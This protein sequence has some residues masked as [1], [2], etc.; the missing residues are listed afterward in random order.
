MEDLPLD[1]LRHYAREG[2]R[3]FALERALGE[4]RAV[5]R[6][7]RVVAPVVFA[8][9]VERVQTD[10]SISAQVSVGLDR[11]HSAVLDDAAIASIEAALDDA[12]Q[13]VAGHGERPRLG[14]RLP[15]AEEARYGVGGPS[16]ALATM[17]SAV[18]A[19]TGQKP[20][21]SVLVTGSF[22]HEIDSLEPKLQ[23]AKRVARE[24]D[25][26]PS[27]PL[28]VASANRP[29]GE[30]FKWV[31][32]AR[33]AVSHVF[34]SSP[35][36][37][38]ARYACVHIAA[39]PRM[40][41]PPA[42]FE[43]RDPAIVRLYDELGLGERLMRSSDLSAALELRIIEAFTNGRCYEVSGGGP[44]VLAAWLG[45]IL[46]SHGA[47]LRVID[48][49]DNAPCWDNRSII[50]PPEGTIRR[51]ATGPEGTTCPPGWELVKISPRVEPP[52]VAETVAAVM[53]SLSPGRIDVAVASS[54]G[55]AWGLGHA[56]K[57]RTA[58]TFH[59]YVK[60]AQDYE[61]WFTG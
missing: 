20:R 28:I 59:H 50:P 4:A 57:N 48:S 24:L 35:W 1:L 58:A 33:E 46:K 9:L 47:A 7:E 6:Q 18:T 11:D 44:V 54:L 15:L 51:A 41:Q 32:S 27:S 29:P 40:T 43:G 16:L 34:G 49:R 30:G 61:P 52:A 31:G 53:K 8:P 23:L 13:V 37:A 2:N 42:R 3:D 55:V 17:L 45:G 38:S 12:W 21:R 60:G 5:I 22:R 56:L 19:L 14:V 26:D 36:H 25:L 10:R 39:L